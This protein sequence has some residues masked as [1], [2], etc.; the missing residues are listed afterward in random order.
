MEA[1]TLSADKLAKD[2][3]TATE[4]DFDVNRVKHLIL[5]CCHAIYLGG[6][7]N[8]ADAAEW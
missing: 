4:H 7:T 8:G 6:P 2:I 5:V 1:T 3:A